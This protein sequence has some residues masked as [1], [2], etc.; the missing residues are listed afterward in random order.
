MIFNT[1]YGAKQKNTVEIDFCD[2]RS[3][4]QNKYCIGYRDVNDNDIVFPVTVTMTLTETKKYYTPNDFNWT[5]VLSDSQPDNAEYLEFPTSYT[6]DN[7]NLRSNQTIKSVCIPDTVSGALQYSA[8]NGCNNLRSV[9]I[10]DLAT[11][12]PSYCFSNCKKLT[13]FV[14]PFNCTLVGTLA[15]ASCEALEQI[16]FNNSITN[17][18]SYAFMSTGL[19]SV[20]MPDSIVIV[21]EYCFYDCKS[22]RSVRLSANLSNLSEGVFAADIALQRVDGDEVY[23][24]YGGAFMG[25]TSLQKPIE[26]SNIISL[27]GNEQFKNCTSMTGTIFINTNTP[28]NYLFHCER[29]NNILID[30]SVRTIGADAFNG[31]LS[32]QGLTIPSNATSIGARAYKDCKQLNEIILPNGITSVA[33]DCFSGCDNVINITLSNYL[34][35]IGSH[36]IA[37]AE[38][39]NID[40]PASVTS[41]SANGLIEVKTHQIT[42]QGTTPPTLGN[43]AFNLTYLTKIRVPQG[44]LSAYTSASSWSAYISLLE[45]Y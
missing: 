33:Q 21:Q 44:S 36:G 19:T 39:A 34:T 17:I 43:S 2:M 42:M 16:V 3:G 8:F 35:T 27:S 13:N 1:I 15:F 31:C 22:L 38:I 12:I 29:L 18:G 45:E 30:D 5:P 24:V 7:V 28:S 40:I 37:S 11:T 14:F 9:H 20:N 25:C 10:S 23:A 32:A 41:I 26:T 4:S 6:L